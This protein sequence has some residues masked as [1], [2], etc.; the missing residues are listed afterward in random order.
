MVGASS[1]PRELGSFWLVNRP[2]EVSNIEQLRSG[3][4]GSVLPLYRGVASPSGT[5]APVRS[6]WTG[7]ATVLPESRAIIIP[8]RLG[9]WPLNALHKRSAPSIQNIRVE[10]L[11]IVQ[12]LT[13][14]R[15]TAM[16]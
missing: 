1:A 4:R 3:R 14:W 7:A 16:R 11:I 12:K 13:Q 10:L 8:I 5:V 9:S 15:T 2:V 6:P